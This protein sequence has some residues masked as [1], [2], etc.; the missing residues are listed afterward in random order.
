MKPRAFWPFALLL[1]LL[2]AKLAYSQKP[3]VSLSTNSL[4]F[5][6]QA[7]VSAS[8]SQSITLTN[9]GDAPLTISNM[10]ITNGDF[11]GSATSTCPPNT[12]IAVK[13]TCV[14]N[15]TFTPEAVG[16]R[17]GGLI[18]TDNDGGVANS[19]Q[20]VALTGTGV[21]AEAP[22]S[23]TA[24]PQT[25]TSLAGNQGIP[26]KTAL[27]VKGN[28]SVQAVLIP[29]EIS[30]RV[31]GKEIAKKYA[32]IQL[33]INNRSADAALIVQGAFIDYRDWV[34]AGLAFP[35]L[36]STNQ[37]TCANGTEQEVIKD[38]KVQS[39]NQACTV[40]TQVASVESRIARGE[41]LDS[42]P[43][44]ARNLLVN[45]LTLLGSVASAYTFS[46]KQE[47]YIKGIAA[48]NGTAVPGLGVFLPDGT[49]G[50]L[51]R[52]SDFGYQTNKV[53][54]KQGSDIIVCFFP[55]DRFLT[56]GFKKIFLHEPALL[57]SPYQVLLDTS[58]RERT[59]APR[60]NHM[61]VN[62]QDILDQLG[63]TKD[64]V[65][66]LAKDLPCFLA[67]SELPSSA[68]DSA[69]RPPLEGALKAFAGS[70]ASATP[71]NEL[72]L[73]MT[74]GKIS[75]NSIR[76]VIDGIM[77][78]ETGAIPAKIDSV[79]FDDGNNNP[80]LWTTSGVKKGTIK[81]LYLTG[82]KLT[83]AEAAKLGITQIA[84]IT[85]GSTDQ[86]LRFSFNISKPVPVGEKLTFVV[87]KTDSKD[88][89]KT[90]DSMSYV[91]VISYPLE[92][93]TITDVTYAD[94]K[95]TVKGT[96]FV[97]TT[98]NPLKVVL[99]PSSGGSDVT[100]KPATTS[101]PTEIDLDAP[102]ALKDPGCWEV[103]VTVGTALAPSGNNNF[104]VETE[105]GTTSATI[106][107][108][109]TKTV[110]VDGQGFVDT[111]KCKGGSPLVFQLVPDKQGVKTITVE[112]P[113]IVSTTKVTFPL[114][115]GVQAATWKVQVSPATGKKAPAPATLTLKK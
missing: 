85:D 90:V 76:V 11:T 3:A 87:S 6:S 99:H 115:A 114:P 31:F 103:R 32:I 27:T 22:P 112:K 113:D 15:V 39:P 18:I 42:Q 111:S 12:P 21:A 7:L 93:P 37:T 67:M 46:I 96:N 61:V 28:V 72:A 36:N 29:Y 109:S 73:L 13:K 81:G 55:I 24:Q 60:F 106:S 50:Q 86:A 26:L 108:T 58:A 80:A 43:W 74:I 64:K 48:F 82:G 1:S 45:G 52:I 92:P 5:G 16:I 44:T 54:S 38:T 20:V 107:G 110:E 95:I 88:A 101:T 25:A 34:L 53:I 100:V 62:P 56:P 47:G 51:N 33:S 105:R 91:F 8:A 98:L 70:C 77:T 68:S 63:I 9:N 2:S 75:L 83:I 69:T 57:L 102:L 78:V 97:D 30:R 49:V 4:S 41:L 84:M 65:K 19:Q 17:F 40:P 94:S 66:D 14:I 89:T 35:Q 23:G 59:F 10:L 104:A 71:A 79:D